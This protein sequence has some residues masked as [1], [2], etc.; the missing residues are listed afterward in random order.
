M[1]QIKFSA[2]CMS[3]MS[4][5]KRLNGK[6]GDKRRKVIEKYGYNTK[7]ASN[8]IRIADGGIDLISHGH[9]KLPYENRELIRDIKN[10]KYTF[11]EFMSIALPKTK[12]LES[13]TNLKNKKAEI[14]DY[15]ESNL[16][17]CILDLGSLASLRF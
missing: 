13:F 5:L 15:A 9:L 1:V 8:V 3:E 10:G 7:S 4:R 6:T 17:T 12:K 16:I 2:Y 14:Y 11:E